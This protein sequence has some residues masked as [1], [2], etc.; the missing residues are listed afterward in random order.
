MRIVLAVAFVAACSFPSTRA[1]VIS[2]AN[3]TCTVVG[4]GGMACNGPG[5]I[6]SKTNKEDKNLPKL[7]VIH[8]ILRPG[9]ALNQPSF[10]SDCLIIGID[11]GDLLNEKTPLLHV[12]LEKGSITL[13]PKEQPFRLR[14][15]GSHDVELQLIEIRR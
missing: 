7:I 2:S 4:D 9:A 14:N 11:R 10:S 12:S 5:P 15:T 8:V 13:M 3:L 6:V 1:Q